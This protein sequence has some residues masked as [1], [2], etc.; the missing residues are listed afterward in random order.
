[1]IHKSPSFLVVPEVVVTTN[2]TRVSPGSAATLFCSVIRGNPM[3]YKYSWNSDGIILREISDTLSLYAFGIDN[4]GTYTCLVTNE[5]GTGMDSVRIELGGECPS[6]TAM[7]SKQ[8]QCNNIP[9][10]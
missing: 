7:T 8:H 10:H 3:A 2:R 1:M 9:L 6:S 5:A 4:E